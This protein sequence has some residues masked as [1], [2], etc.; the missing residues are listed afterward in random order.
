MSDHHFNFLYYFIHLYSLQIFKIYY[1][2]M[3]MSHLIIPMLSYNYFNL[4]ISLYPI[5]YRINFI[6]FEYIELP[7]NPIDKFRCQANS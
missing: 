1:L 5:K 3:C 7:L 4:F 2:I 6:K